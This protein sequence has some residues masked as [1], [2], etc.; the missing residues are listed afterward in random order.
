ME[1]VAVKAALKAEKPLVLQAKRKLSFKDKHALETLPEKLAVLQSELKT[2]E[3]KLGD[4][5]LFTRDA[6]LFE[7][8]SMRHAAAFEELQRAEEQWLALEIMREELENS[9]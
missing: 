4:A 6:K 8:T 5:G 7:S 9:A 3:A 1:K 2:L